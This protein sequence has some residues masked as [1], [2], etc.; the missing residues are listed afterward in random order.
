MTN[1]VVTVTTDH[2]KVEFNDATPF[3]GYKK[4]T[5]RKDHI[6]EI[7]LDEDES[8]VEIEAD[9]GE[10]WIVCHTGGTGMVVDS[11]DGTNVTSTS[12]LYTLIDGVI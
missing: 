1:I 10:K 6:V 11:V 3:V 5:I 7:K 4:L 2:F 9:N 8:F 12:Q